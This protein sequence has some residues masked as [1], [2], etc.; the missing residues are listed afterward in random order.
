[1]FLDPKSK[2]KLQVAIDSTLFEMESHSASSEEFG[3]MLDRVKQLH[4]LKEEE[5]PSRP[6]PDT[7]ILV[8]QSRRHRDDP[9]SRAPERHHVQ[10]AKFRAEVEVND[11]P[12]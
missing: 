1:M 2:S 7:L 9:P 12:L 6:S 10:G 4:K 8:G 3:T 11:F 5:K